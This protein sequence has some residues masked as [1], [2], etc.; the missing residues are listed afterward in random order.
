MCLLDPKHGLDT[1]GGQSDSPKSCSKLVAELEA[2]FDYVW[3]LFSLEGEE[4]VVALIPSSVNSCS[5]T[6]RA[7]K[8]EKGAFIAAGGTG[9]RLGRS[10]PMASLGR[11]GTPRL[12]NWKGADPVLYRAEE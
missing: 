4:C 2:E 9:L 1:R 5:L 8:W 6:A 11:G 10:V 7:R 3:I 12:E